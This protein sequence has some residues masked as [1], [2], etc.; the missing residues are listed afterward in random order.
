MRSKMKTTATKEDG[1]PA[2]V[3]KLRFP[4][5]RGAEGWEESKLKEL[6][7][8]GLSN[9]VFND[10]KK[11]GTGYKLVNVLDMYLDTTINE[12]RLSL[13]ELSVSEFEKNQV[14]CG[15]IFFTRSSLVK[16]GIAVSNIYLGTSN[17]ITFDGHLIRFRSDTNKVVPLFAH[18][19]FKTAPIRSQLVARGKSA[20]M[21]TIGQSDVEGV[22]LL[23][24]Q[25][26]E[27]QKIAECLSSVD[28]LIA[29]QARKLDALKTHKKGLMQQLFPREGETQPRLRFPEFQNA[30]EWVEKRLDA[31]CT[32]Q[33]GKFSHRPR[34]DPRFFDGQY[35]FI[36]TGDVVKSNGGPVEA[37][38]SLNELGLSVSKLFK[39]PIVLITIAANIGDTG[40]LD[41]EAC[42]TDSVVGLIPNKN[43]YPRFLELT[44]REKKE[45]LNKIAP[46]AA[47]KNINNEILSVLL[48]LVPEFSEQ[49][50][51]AD[52][53]TSLD[54]LIT[55]QTQKLD[56][57]KTH[58]KGLMQQL[59]PS[60]EA[61][62]A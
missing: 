8:L 20:T 25:K 62:E 22:T 54:D 33:R 60:P 6:C 36:Q 29:A 34:N 26:P 28:E 47:Q 23:Y 3:P 32:I 56:G 17:N 53:L 27:Q 55:A 52:C 40:M 16:S 4:E 35:P 24:P 61:V 9:G 39:P 10:P 43:V 31:I 41:R 7:S 11:V 18:Y 1:K 5:F 48:V 51:I 57:L 38:Q 49:Q 2:L 30:G 21:T 50:C 12:D 58:K 14:E 59:F 37:S 15:D 45:Y 44:V 46:A 13:L 19:L 42:F